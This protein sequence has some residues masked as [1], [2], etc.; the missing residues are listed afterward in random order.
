[1]TPNWPGTLQGQI[2]LYMYKWC[3]DYQISRFTV[4]PALFGIQAILRQ[5]H[6]MTP[7][8]L[9]TLQG[10]ITLY[11]CMY[12]SCPWF[13]NFIPLCCMTSH[14]WYTGNFDTS[15]LNDPKITLNTTRSKVPHI[16]VTSF[17]ESQISPH[18]GLW[19]AGFEIQAILRQ[20]HRMTPNDLE[21]YTAM[22]PIYVLLV[23]T[24]P[25]LH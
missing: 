23:S 25:I 16:C 24:S 4:Q 12:K 2:T 13:P 20:G 3:P 22:C 11:T 1:M 18:F 5:V 17:H 15:A 19:P 21:H 14:F 9:W 7:N 8:W 6:R 10:Q